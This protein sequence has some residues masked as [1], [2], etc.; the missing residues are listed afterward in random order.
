MMGQVAYKELAEE[1][2]WSVPPPP[3]AL[4]PDAPAGHRYQRK[5]LAE[6]P[7]LRHLAYEK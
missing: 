4:L 7:R 2:D 1:L 5:H 3:S 6:D